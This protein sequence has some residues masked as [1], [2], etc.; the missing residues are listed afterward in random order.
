MSQQHY[1]PEFKKKLVRL[2][3]EEGHTLQNPSTEYGVAKSSITIQCRKFSNKYREQTLTNPIAPNELVQCIIDKQLLD[4]AHGKV[5]TH[6]Q[7][8]KTNCV[9]MSTIINA[10][11]LYSENGIEGIITLKRNVNSDNARR[12]LDG[13]AEARIIEIACSPAPKGYSRWTLRLLEEQSKIV[14]DVPV[15][16]DTIGRALKKINFDLT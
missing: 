14:L 3:L 7:S 8:A 13:R 12:K 1:E 10:E 9:C 2:H 5:L 6:K 16:K 4:D 11:R 15:S